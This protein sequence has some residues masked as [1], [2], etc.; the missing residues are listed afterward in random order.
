[1]AESAWIQKAREL[2]AA[3]VSTED[4]VM[5]RALRDEA[6]L[7]DYDTIEKMC[8]ERDRAMVSGT[9]TEGEV[10][11]AVNLREQRVRLETQTELAR[12]RSQV[13]DLRA[14]VK[15]WENTAMVV[16]CAQIQSKELAVLVADT[17][18]AH[19]N[20]ITAIVGKD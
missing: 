14:L 13:A 8:E 2:L 17:V 3:G 18:Q 4:I 10:Q 20:A 6:P 7:R 1:M 12:L 19:A 11:L 15:T 9:A 5:D 16:R